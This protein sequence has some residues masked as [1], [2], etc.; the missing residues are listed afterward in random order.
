MA[1]ERVA[2]T[3]RQLMQL[4]RLRLPRHAERRVEER[5]RGIGRGGERK[6]AYGGEVCAGL[7]PTLES[8][9]EVNAADGKA[10]KLS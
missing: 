6:S 7:L 2:E 10:S 9:A 3:L 4:L 5:W 8:S 1:A